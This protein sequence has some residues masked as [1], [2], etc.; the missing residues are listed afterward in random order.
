MKQRKIKTK[1]RTVR[2]RPMVKE[3]SWYLEDNRFTNIAAELTDSVQA[4]GEARKTGADETTLTGLREAARELMEQHCVSSG[5]R[6]AG[7]S[8]INIEAEFFSGGN[9]DEAALET[10]IKNIVKGHCYQKVLW[11]YMG[12]TGSLTQISRSEMAQQGIEYEDYLPVEYKRNHPE[13]KPLEGQVGENTVPVY[14]YSDGSVSETYDKKKTAYRF[15]A[16]QDRSGIN[17]KKGYDPNDT[18]EKTGWYGNFDQEGAWVMVENTKESESSGIS[19]GK[20]GTIEIIKDGDTA[21]LYDPGNLLLNATELMYLTEAGEI[22]GS[23]EPDPEGTVEL[24]R[25]QLEELG[26]RKISAI[27][28]PGKTPSL[29]ETYRKALGDLTTENLTILDHE[30]LRKVKERNAAAL[31]AAA[32]EAMALQIERTV[33]VAGKLTGNGD[34]VKRALY[35]GNLLLPLDPIRTKDGELLGLDAAEV[36][37]IGG[38]GARTKQAEAYSTIL[39]NMYAGWPEIAGSG[40]GKVEMAKLV[41]QY[42]EG[43]LKDIPDVTGETTIDAI[44]SGSK[45]EMKDRARLYQ[46]GI[47]GVYGPEEIIDFYDTGAREAYLKNLEKKQVLPE[48]GTDS[49]MTALAHL[50][51]AMDAEKKAALNHALTRGLG[52]YKAISMSTGM[53]ISEVIDAV[54]AEALGKTP[55]GLNRKVYYDL[56]LGELIEAAKQGNRQKREVDVSEVL[57]PGASWEIPGALT[58]VENTTAIRNES[59]SGAGVVIGGVNGMALDEMG[60]DRMVL[61]EQYGYGGE[62]AASAESLLHGI[63]MP[64]G[65]NE[66]GRAMIATDLE[67][68]LKE[69]KG[70]N[71]GKLRDE[72]REMYAGQENTRYNLASEEGMEAYLGTKRFKGSGLT[73]SE[74]KAMMGEAGNGTRSAS[75]TVTVTP[76][77]RSRG[78]SVSLERTV[79]KGMPER[80]TLNP[81]VK[82]ADKPMKLPRDQDVV[83]IRESGTELRNRYGD[84]DN[85]PSLIIGEDTEGQSVEKLTG[86]NAQ[87][88]E[89]QYGYGKEAAAEA[90]EVLESIRVPAGREK[91]YKE[92]VH[93]V[94]EEMLRGNRDSGGFGKM[95]SGTLGRRNDVAYNLGSSS[96]LRG[97]MESPAFSQSGLGSSDL[98]GY[99]QQVQNSGGRNHNFGGGSPVYARNVHPGTFPRLD[100]V[101][102]SAGY[103]YD[104]DISPIGRNNPGSSDGLDISQNISQP[105]QEGKIYQSLSSMMQ[106]SGPADV[107][108]NTNVNIPVQ[109]NIEAPRPAAN[110]STQ[111]AELERL[112]RIEANYERDKAALVRERQPVLA[113]SASHDVG[114]AEGNLEQQPSNPIKMG[115]KVLD[116]FADD[117]KDLLS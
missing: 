92:Q 52:Q 16:L 57:E 74:L 99:I 72:I 39:S 83:M 86:L 106:N 81:V 48:G 17:W 4:Y 44:F 34:E 11:T 110:M 25:Q 96:G 82:D 49:A 46:S 50:P 75:G 111:D 85:V 64:E 21:I 37:E 9:L 88:L 55:A 1:N 87:V 77:Y 117:A 43:S 103:H 104:M 32:A 112:R 22:Y 51:A 10:F 30:A 36:E 31:A 35:E 69:H 19:A 65:A 6:E 78:G 23:L 45:T 93:P 73:A 68:I 40:I 76:K 26:V 94:I 56:P 98:M 7:A 5:L 89:D 84:D 15:D 38:Y 20:I 28:G 13:K 47:P 63:R 42:L 105:G 24:I 115:K 2:R 102:G 79:P 90:A 8:Y 80:I 59:Q 97:Y 61:M 41:S 71:T 33:T 60:F 58:G 116:A 91:Q 3:L 114:H 107:P 53:K 108:A 29:E 67:R 54:L 70:S 12:T 101:Y 66:T 109:G 95:L 14:M 113:R 100:Q 62:E 18:I 27:G